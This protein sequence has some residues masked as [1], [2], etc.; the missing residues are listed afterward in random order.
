LLLTGRTSLKVFLAQHVFRD[1]LGRRGSRD[2][3]NHALAP[4]FEVDFG[5][6]I[7]G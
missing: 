2:T 4:L 1:G 7:L 3:C 5:S 6:Y